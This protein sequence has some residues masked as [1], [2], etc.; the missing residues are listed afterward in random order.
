MP[1]VVFLAVWATRRRFYIKRSV[2]EWLISPQARRK[3]TPCLWAG[4][5]NY[6]GYQTAKLRRDYCQLLHL[7]NSIRT[8]LSG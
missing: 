6:A 3:F 8:Y 2:Q 4:D 1:L 5:H 7:P